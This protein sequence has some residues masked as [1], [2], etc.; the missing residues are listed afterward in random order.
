MLSEELYD[1]I[2]HWIPGVNGSANKVLI[3]FDKRYHH[4]AEI[5]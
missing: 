2:Q 1:D 5:F 4:H 3:S